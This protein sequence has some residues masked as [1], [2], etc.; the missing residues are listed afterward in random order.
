MK[1]GLE[2]NRE[3]QGQRNDGQSRIGKTASGKKRASSDEE[4]GHVMHPAIGVD[5]AVPWIVMHPG[6]T[7]KVMRAVELPGLTA[8]TFLYRDESADAGCR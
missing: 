8:L 6:G 4:I 7:E 2:M 3:T 1:F 5:H